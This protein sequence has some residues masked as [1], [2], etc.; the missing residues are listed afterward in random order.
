MRVG[1]V[2]KLAFCTTPVGM[3]YK[4]TPDLVFKIPSNLA[5]SVFENA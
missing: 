1:S 2:V 4:V 3:N 5:L